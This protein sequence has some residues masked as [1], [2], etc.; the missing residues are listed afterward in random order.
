MNRRLRR[1]VRVTLNSKSE[2]R[3]RIF[4]TAAVIA[5]A[6]VATVVLTVLWG[7]ALGRKAEESRLKSEESSRYESHESTGGQS[8]KAPAAS[9][10]RNAVPV[11]A[12][13]YKVLS[14]RNKI[15][16]SSDAATLKSNGVSALSMVLYYGGGTLNFN[17]K[18]AQSMGYQSAGDYTTS[19]PE[20]LRIL[21][22]AGIYTSGCFYVNY[23]TK[24]T[25]ALR[26]VYRSYEAG[27]LAETAE[28]GFSELLL[29]NFP[30]SEDGA[31]EAGRL[32]EEVQWLDAGGSVKIGVALPYSSL[33]DDVLT[34][35][36]AVADFLAFDFSNVAGEEN[37]LAAIDG[38][39]GY[40][41]TYNARVVIPSSL[42]EVKIKFGEKGIKNWQIIPD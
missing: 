18:L 16:W 8:F 39:A 10:N 12:A 35:F 30:A 23:L 29:F 13:E 6:F 25:P 27:L 9:Y 42:T 33:N 11:I 5:A 2:E 14:S 20:P 31:A 32:I 28:S 37:L 4:K 19:L 15:N 3:S 41:E 1:R 7:L 38:K 40:I 24:S 21:K 36:A 26:A 34:A 17:S 22:E